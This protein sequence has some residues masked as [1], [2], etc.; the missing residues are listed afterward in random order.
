MAYEIIPISLGHCSGVAF[1]HVVG[2]GV[3]IE[4]GGTARELKGW[5]G[6][7]GERR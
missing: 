1:G 4:S 5:G 7:G 3:L 6:V 2:T